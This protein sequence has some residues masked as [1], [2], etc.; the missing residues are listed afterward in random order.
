MPTPKEIIQEF[1]RKQVCRDIGPDLTKE[2]L[3][4][5]EPER[6]DLFEFAVEMTRSY[7]KAILRENEE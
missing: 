1:L 5:D 7:A 2:D 6:S 3:H 4:P